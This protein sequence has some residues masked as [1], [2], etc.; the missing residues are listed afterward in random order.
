[1]CS[2]LRLSFTYMGRDTRSHQEKTGWIDAITIHVS[3]AVPHKPGRAKKRGGGD[4]SGEALEP[5]HLCARKRAVVSLTCGRT[6]IIARGFLLFPL[7][8]P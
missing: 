6:V 7:Q 5:L 1:M 3:S 8:P 4:L 2:I